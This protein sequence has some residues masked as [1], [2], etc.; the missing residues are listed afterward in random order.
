MLLV[1]SCFKSSIIFYKTLIKRNAFLREHSNSKHKKL[2]TTD[3]ASKAKVVNVLAKTWF[4][5]V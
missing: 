2:N 1:V 3:S 5:K 4:I